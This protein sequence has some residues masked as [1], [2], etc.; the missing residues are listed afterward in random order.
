M[1]RLVSAACAA[2]LLATPVWAQTQTTPAKPKK[3]LILVT[4][5]EIDA[6]LILAPPAPE[7]SPET[8]AEIAE[9][10]REIDSAS[11][12]RLAQARWDG[13]HESPELLS[14]VLGPAFDLKALPATAELLALVQNDADAAAGAAKK[15]FPRKRPWAADPTIHACVTGEKPMNSYPSGH[16]TLG[17]ALAL[18][19]AQVMPQRADLLLARAKA[20]GYSREICGDHYPSDV[21]AS[22]ALA[23][24]LIYTLLTKPEFQAKLEAARTELTSKGLITR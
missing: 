1:N 3:A 12:E 19:M 24:A 9:V 22:E 10:H 23:T 5:A 21:Q 18:T 7:G 8:L 14:P 15:T 6:R 4:A 17:Y 2:T 16:G 11:P 13:E 20:Y